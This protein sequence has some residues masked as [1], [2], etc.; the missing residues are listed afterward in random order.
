MTGCG[1]KDTSGPTKLTMWIMPNSQEPDKDVKAVLAKFEEA[2]PNIQV[3]VESL[4]W[5]SA[6][7]KIT[8]AATSGTGPDIV[9]LGSTWVGMVSS[10]EA[11]SDLT[12]RVNSI[13]GGNLFVPLAWQTSQIAGSGKVTAIPWIV[14]A[15]AMFYRTDV[16]RKLGLTEKDLA[17]WDS[18]EKTL[19]K[20][21]K[22]DL[23]INGKKVAPLGITGKNDWNVVHNLAPWIWAGGGQFL[24]DDNKNA[25]LSK[26][27]AANGINFYINLASKGYVPLYCLEKNSYQIS[28]EF[29]NGSYAIYFDGP[30]ALKTLTTPSER[31]GAADLPVA[32]NFGVAP[33]PQGPKGRFTYGGGSALAIFKYSK[34]QDAAWK[35]VEYLTTNQEAQV[36]YAKLTGFLP[37]KKEAFQDSYFSSDSQVKVFTHSVEFARNYPCIPYWGSLEMTTL[38]RR[39]GLMWSEAMANVKD[40]GYDKIVKQM[41]IADQEIDAVLAQ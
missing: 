5:G 12:E 11:L 32:K 37:S 31:G 40:Y 15:R 36:A 17:T 23:T 27:D 2:N 22:A 19:A 18:F 14:D 8:A 28:S 21:K 7:Q 3:V 1:S 38:Q 26:S 41:Q 24:T 35:V 29:V 6:W 20:I 10:M 25:N 39:F 9:Q 4:D 16:F 30:Y 34:K 13:G 33:Y